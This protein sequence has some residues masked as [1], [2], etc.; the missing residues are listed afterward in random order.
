MLEILIPVFSTYF[1]KKKK[2]EK[3]MK[4]NTAIAEI[5]EEKLEKLNFFFFNISTRNNFKVEFVQLVKSFYRQDFHNY[6]M[7][8]NYIK[9]LFSHQSK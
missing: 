2:G 1:N 4:G 9:S 3:E 6:F 8:I 7:F 5:T